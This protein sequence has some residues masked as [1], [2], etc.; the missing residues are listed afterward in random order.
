MLCPQCKNETSDASQFCVYCGAQLS[1]APHVG[2]KGQSSPPPPQQR[3]ATSLNEASA[4]ISDSVSNSASPDPL[5]GN[6]LDE[7]YEIIS[8]LG[9]GGMGTVY[10]A[11]RVA[12]GDEVAVKILHQKFVKDT[13]AVERFRRE[14]R[15]AARLHHPNIVGIHDF[16]ETHEG[17]ER[18]VFIVM[19]LIDGES[20]RAILQREMSLPTERAVALMREICAGVGAAH[21]NSIVHRDLKPDNIICVARDAYGERETVKVVDFGIAKLRDA[22]DSATSTLTQA[23]MIMGTPYYMSPEQCRGEA[24]DSRAD[25]YSL[26]AILYEML[27]GRPPFVAPTMTGIVAKHLTEPPPPL[28]V[29]AGVTSALD[30]VVQRA[31]AKSPADRQPDATVFLNELKA[32]MEASTSHINNSSTAQTILA[33][34][35][36]QGQPLPAVATP[37]TVVSTPAAASHPASPPLSYP[38]PVFTG[39]NPQAPNITLPHSQPQKSRRGW[40]YAVIFLFVIGLLG[41]VG[42]GGLFVLSDGNLAGLF[43][44]GNGNTTPSPRPSPTRSPSPVDPATVRSEVTEA[45]NRWVET[46]ISRNIDDHMSTYAQTLET[47]YNARNVPASRVREDRSRAFASYD[48]INIEIS[49]LRVVPEG[50]AGDRATATFDKTWNF[51]GARRSSGSVQ[52]RLWL[53][54]VNNR[55]V[56]TGERDLQ[57][58]YRNTDEA[59]NDGIGDNPIDDSG[60]DDNIPEAGDADGR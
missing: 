59:E 27:A 26:A 57:L 11:R 4:P 44:S 1:P 6:V 7:R 21:R 41:A 25:V 18:R 14:A 29:R 45:V 13:A 2:D 43:G 47:Y 55:W 56:I 5:I 60:G 30:W 3:P 8:H 37:P 34:P 40:L 52:Q 32:A 39:T 15:A 58:Y 42:A 22:T 23:G 31:L 46:T 19:E 50:S 54:K 28:P 51:Q 33:P 36:Q 35:Q 10:R 38:P 16:G 20:L 12:L 9:E 49:N 53:T 24:L 17:G 48:V